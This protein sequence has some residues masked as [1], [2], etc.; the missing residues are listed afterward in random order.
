MRTLQ[1][2]KPLAA[3]VVTGAALYFTR[4][5]LDQHETAQRLMRIAL[6]PPWQSLLGFTCLAALVLLVVDRMNTR[7]GTTAGRRPRLAELVLPLFFLI[8]LAVPFVPVLPDRWPVLQALATPMAAVVWLTVAGLQLWVLWQ[9]RLITARAI[10]RWSVTRIAIAIFAATAALAGLA[11]SQLTHTPVFPGGDEPHYL[12]IAQSLWRD[13]DLKIENNHTRGDYAEYYNHPL[14]PHFLRRGTDG[15]IYSVHP[16][17]MPVLMAPVFGAAGYLGVVWALILIGA[18]AATLAWWWAIGAVKSPGAA[19]FAWAAIAASAPFLFNTFTVYP[20]V[21][22]A[23]AVMIAVVLAVKAAPE[24]PGLWRWLAIGAAGAALPWFSTKYLPMSAALMAVAGCRA[25]GSDPF[26][27]FRKGSAPYV[28]HKMACL[29]TPYVLSLAGWF[30]FFY[31]YWGSALPSAPYGDLVQ[32]TPLNLLFGA[33]G[34]LFDQEY[35]LLAFAPAY[36]LAVTGLVI[37]WK[38]G[39]DMRRQAIEIVVIFGALLASVGAFRIWWGGSSA[40]SRPIAS[41]LLLF[42]VPIAVAFRAAPEGSARRAAQ[43]LLLWIGVAIGI[44]LAVAQ[45]GLLIDNGRDGTAALLEYWSPRWGMWSLAPTFTHDETYIASLHTLWWLAVAAGAAIVLA[46]WR[47]LQP[48]AAALAAAT[49]FGGALLILALTMPL[50]PSGDPRPAV[51][52][53]ARSRLAALDAFDSRV[54]PVAVLYDPLRRVPAADVVPLLSMGVKPQQRTDPQPLRVIHNGRFSLPAGTYEL[55]VLFGKD[56]P[57]RPTTLSLQVGRVGPPLY[58]WT[59]QPKPGERHRTSLRLAVD[60]SFVGFRGP[61]EMERAIAGITITPTTVID[62]GARPKVPTTLS[63]AAYPGA[64]LYFHNEQMYPEPAGF[65]TVGKR[66]V[67]VTVAVAPGQPMPIVLRVHSGGQANEAVFST[68]GWLRRYQLQPGAAV[69]VALPIVPGGVI[70]LTI[71]T[72]SGFQPRDLDP[73]SRDTRFLGIW[74]EIMEK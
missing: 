17:G 72:N 64:T 5:V 53:G 67:E 14:E 32:T 51:D 22:A 60:A 58:S 61:I 68:F 62:A 18:A 29:I 28:R 10:E 11:A 30:A 65:W 55:D 2:I 48:G 50:L 1:L 57:L 41:G 44:T 46:R 45:G 73:A 21:C 43:H 42:A 70:P 52:L 8:V 23:L 66:S 25:Q 6:L 56:V 19:T 33:P 12:V 36:I 3:C 13:G 31:I 71:S 47:D 27:V 34:L 35:G 20:E 59:L 38:S 54:R 4:G 69:D 9:S 15:E 63:A 40:P 74:V 24:A 39:G 7:R 26:A 49:V 37:M 16:I